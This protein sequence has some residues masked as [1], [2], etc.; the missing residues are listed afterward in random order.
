MEMMKSEK[1]RLVV[2]VY[3]PTFIR[4]FNWKCQHYLTLSMA[5]PFLLVLAS[6]LLNP[7]GYETRRYCWMSIEG[8]IQYSFIIPVLVL[9]T[10]NTLLMLWV[11]KRYFER[12]PM[13][14]RIHLVQI[15]P[16]LRASITL[17][18]FFS[19]NWFLSVLSLETL[20][21]TPFELIFAITNCLHSFMVF[22][23][24]CYQRYNFASIISIFSFN[25]IFKHFQL[26]G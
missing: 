6:Y 8:G 12:K 1:L 5:I 20:Q 13:T 21:T 25:I 19:L 9:I 17:L 23:F 15:R 3:Y 4:D 2:A 26:S 14:H 11:L 7:R 16:S 22:Y 10:T 24:H 18:P